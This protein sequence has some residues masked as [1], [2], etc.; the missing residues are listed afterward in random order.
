MATDDKEDDVENFKK[1]RKREAELQAFRDW[2]G[3]RPGKR[4]LATWQTDKSA[5]PGY[6]SFSSPRN[7]TGGPSAGP[8][9]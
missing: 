3:R 1:A 8:P 4:R 9:L 6:P 7:N 5:K 2:E